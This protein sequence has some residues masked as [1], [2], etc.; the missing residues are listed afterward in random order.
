MRNTW[1]VFLSILTSSVLA[2]TVLAL[3]RRTTNPA[4]DQGA[5]KVQGGAQFQSVSGKIASVQSNSFILETN[6]G[7]PQG[8]Q[9][10]QAQGQPK[11]MTFLIDENTAVD[12]KLRVGANAD[13]AYRQQNGNNV[14]VSVRVTSE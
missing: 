13:V 8:E 2:A 11:T 6:E 9:F 7:M 10:R 1:R 12:G 4:P 5:S 14:A 3:P